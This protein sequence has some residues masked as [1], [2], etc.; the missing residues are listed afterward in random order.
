MPIS[1][2]LN[3]AASCDRPM[4]TKAAR[5]AMSCAIFVSNRSVES[6]YSAFR[7]VVLFELCVI[8]SRDLGSGT[9]YTPSNRTLKFDIYCHQVGEGHYNPIGTLRRP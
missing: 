4:R 6:S 8:Q 5:N 9:P 7:T 3:S 2:V 1:S